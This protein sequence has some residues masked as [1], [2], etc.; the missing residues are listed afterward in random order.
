MD[1]IYQNPFRVLG[2]PV[3]SSAKDIAKRIGDI[4]LYAE[5]GK[6][7]EYDVD[8]YFPTQPIRTKESVQEANQAIVQPQN[9]LFHSLF[10]F[11]EG[12]KNT[13]DKMAFNELRNGNIEKALEFWGKEI[14]KG[15]NSRNKSNRK[16]LAI[17]LLGLSQEGGV[18]NKEYFLF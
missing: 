2:L 9:K 17:L 6:P 16:N 14:E 13:V 10:W 11:W 8:H 1:L 12:E 4:S 3:T 15:A 5:M 7:M 18:L